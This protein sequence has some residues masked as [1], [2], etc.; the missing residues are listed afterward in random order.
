MN[1]L[2]P[3]EEQLTRV[4]RE[5]YKIINFDGRIELEGKYIMLISHV[6]SRTKFG[7]NLGCSLRL[8]LYSI[9]FYYMLILT[10]LPLNYIFF[11]YS[12]YLQN[13]KKNQRLI[14]M[15]SI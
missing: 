4:K 3:I 7:Y 5:H 10:N 12:L 14:A 6:F 13:F 11:L 9:Y 1:L 2:W 8:Q 15:S